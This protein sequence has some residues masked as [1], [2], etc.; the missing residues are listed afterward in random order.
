[1]SFCFVCSV[2][3]IVAVN[4]EEFRKVL[5]EKSTTLKAWEALTLLFH[6]SALQKTSLYYKY[7]LKQI[8]NS[9]CQLKSLSVKPVCIMS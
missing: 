4:N 1:M 2:L 5:Y 9:F 6:S 7:A 3:K 8:F